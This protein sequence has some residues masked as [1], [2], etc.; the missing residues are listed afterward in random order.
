MGEGENKGLDGH[1]F[2]DNMVSF[3]FRLPYYNSLYLQHSSGVDEVSSLGYP[4]YLST[5]AHTLYFMLSSS[6][7]RRTHFS[8]G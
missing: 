7:K 8:T 6:L 1:K 5:L 3:V 2:T 4:V